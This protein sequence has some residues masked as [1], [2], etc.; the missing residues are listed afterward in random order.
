MGKKKPW[1]GIATEKS[2]V[3]PPDVSSL[4]KLLEL[5]ECIGKLSDWRRCQWKATGPDEQREIDEELTKRDQW[6]NNIKTIIR[7]QMTFGSEEEQ[8]GT[9]MLLLAGMA[10]QRQATIWQEH[11]ALQ[12]QQ[13]SDRGRQRAEENSKEAFKITR[14]E[15]L[16]RCKK[17]YRMYQCN[18]AE[19]REHVSNGLGNAIGAERVKQLMRVHRITKADYAT[20]R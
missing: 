18:Q 5:C 6:L 16:D 1:Q 15:L 11:M 19:L 4:S 2:I 7:N 3:E 9:H 14:K 10:L 8:Q 17:A 13:Q 20:E 12:A